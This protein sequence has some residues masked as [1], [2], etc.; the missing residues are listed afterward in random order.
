MFGL[1]VAKYVRA[2]K[3]IVHLDLAAR[4]LEGTYEV[5]KQSNV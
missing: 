1:E 4:Q 5:K 3:L 2:T